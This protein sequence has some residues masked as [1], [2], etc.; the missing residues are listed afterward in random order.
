MK[1]FGLFLASFLLIIAF[2]VTSCKKD[3]DDG[4]SNGGDPGP[5]WEM[6][7]YGRSTCTFTNNFKADADSE[8]L[9]YTFYDI[10]QDETKQQEMWGKVNT[11]GMGGG[12]VDL[13]IVDVEIEGQMNLFERPS[14][15]EVLEV[16]P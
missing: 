3:E 12:Q 2:S 13:P 7:V 8:D 11:A 9:E 4:G 15:E 14:I 16:I 1:K 6:F 10:D 5:Q